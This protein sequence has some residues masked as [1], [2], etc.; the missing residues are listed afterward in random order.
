MPDAPGHP[1]VSRKLAAILAADI[2]GYSALMSANEDATVRDLKGHQAVIL[3]M[4]G[5]HGGRVIDTAGDGILAEF[6]SVL[7]AVKCAVA[8]QKTMADRNSSVD[9]ERRMQFRIGVNQGDVLVD[10]ARL[11]GDGINVAARLESIAEPGNICVSGKV[12]E[13][14]RDRVDLSFEDMGEQILKNITRPVRAYRL[15]LD[16]RAT[17]IPHSLRRDTP[18][19]PD[20]PSIAV[21]P[22]SIFSNEPEQE[23]FGDGVVEDIIT[24]LS[25]FRWL[26][27]IARNSSFTYKG[28][29]VDVKQVGRELGVR[30]VLEGSVRK[31]GHRV[32]IIA[33]LIDATSG[34]HLSAD[35]FDGE[36]E[37]IF[38]L[39]EQV[40]AGVAG[41]IAPRL[42]RAEM[43]RVKRKRIESLDAYGYFMRASACTRENTNEANDE[44]L[45]LLNK[46]IEI[47]PNFASAYG[48][49]TWCYCFRRSF[50]PWDEN[51]EQE[52]GKAHRLIARAVELGK[53]DAFALCCAGFARGYIL[54]DLEHAVPLLDRSLALNPNLARAW[55][56]SGWVRIW[57]GQP[58]I[59][60]EHIARAMRLS[61]FDPMLGGMQTAMARAH[62]SAE[63]YAEASAWAEKALREHPNN[64]DA[65][66]IL[67]ASSALNGQTEK[68]RDAMARFLQIAPGRRLSHLAKSRPPYRPDDSARM[69]EGLRRA[70]HP[71]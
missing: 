38:A 5:Q 57:A 33:Q 34:A 20:R 45:Q 18:P 43:E 61:P 32:R 7:N 65:F 26:F 53:D 67:A 58:D 36:L 19:L 31:S 64:T 29:A 60:I 1:N 47:D 55:S 8:I 35:R 70:G 30:Y 25:H 42:E 21:L 15:V 41:I 13:E 24:A 51:R 2:A 44:A 28:R 23:H 39:Q 37:D 14:V 12:H 54:G 17:T 48:L 22:F 62:F 63:R 71:E 59:A 6:S 69:I 68:A 27:V 46:A 16:D 56:F 10:E 66:R 4:V 3:P 40:A 9:P 50:L 49:A 52:V 11:Y